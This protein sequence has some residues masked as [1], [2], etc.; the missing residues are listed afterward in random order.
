[1]KTYISTD[2]PFY[3]LP[4][5]AFAYQQIQDGIRLLDYGCFNGRF[6][7]ELLRHKK[8][9]YFG[10]D[11][12]VG[13]VEQQDPSLR[14]S[15][16]SH[17]LSFPDNYFDVVVAFEVLEHIAD[18]KKTL[19]ELFRVLKEGGILILSVPRKHL[20]SF[21]D[22]ANWKF[23]FPLLHQIYYRISRGNTAYVERYK[24]S[25]SGLV[26]DIEREKAWHQHFGDDEMTGLL[27]ECGFEVR[28]MDASGFFRIL[29]QDIGFLFRI[30]GIF[31]Q[32]LRDWDSYR[33]SSAQLICS[34]I[35]KS[36]K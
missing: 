28:E 12:N 2:S 13:V 21:L 32:R 36:V 7:K 4:N 22:M 24:E 14:I 33:F 3:H 23:V 31:P 20:F 30:P 16:V 6:G 35:K 1:M 18:Q 29:M 5:F 26:G 19:G 34:A 27:E 15:V 25:S 11:K 9:D 10:V 8:V 17:P